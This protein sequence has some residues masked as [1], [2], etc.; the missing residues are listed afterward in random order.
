MFDSLDLPMFDSLELIGFKSFPRKTRLVFKDRVTAIIGPNGCGKSNLSDALG[1][2]LGVQTARDLRGEKM[3]DV[4]FSGTE[5]RRSSGFAEVSLTICRDPKRA[6]L[7]DGKEFNGETLEITRKLYCSG[8][9]I[10]SINQR[11]C[12]LKDIH[13]FLEDAGLQF[14][15]YA[16]IAQGQIESFLSTK[17]LDRR[18]LIEEA[19][20]IT[21]YKNRRRNAELK[22]GMTEQNLL[23][24]NDIIVEVE[25]QL[26]S[27]KR[28]ATKARRYREITEE[29]RQVQ[30]H[31]FALEAQ[32][33]Q[34]QLQILAK[35]LGILKTTQ[36]ELDQK[37]VV[38]GKTHH[39]SFVKR[40]QLEALLAELRQRHSEMVLAVDRAENSIRYQD[41]QIETTQQQLEGN[42]AE[43]RVMSQALERVVEE[44]GCL[45]VEKERLEKEEKKVRAAL[46]GQSELVEHYPSELEQV[47]GELEKLRGR[48]V[49]LSA[50]MESRRNLQDQ[51]KQHLE[52]ALYRRKRLEEERSSHLLKLEESGTRLQEKKREI[53][54]KRTHLGKLRRNLQAQEKEK[55]DLQTQL[56]E[57]NERVVESKNQL[58]AQRERLQSLQEVELNHSQYSEGVQEFLN[59]LSRNQGVHTDGTLADFIEISPEYEKLVEEFLDKELEYLLVDSLDEALRGLSE[60]KCLK[61][62]KCTFLSLNSSNGFG[63]TY[64]QKQLLSLCKQKGVKGTLSELLRMKPEVQEAFHRVL[65]QR[66]EAVVVSDLGRAF[67]L[68]HS[69]PEST[70]LTLEGEVLA[71]RGLLSA[72]VS[73]SKKL[74]LLSLKRQ[75]KTLE[76]NVARFEKSLESLRKDQQRQ[77]EELEKVSHRFA[78][79]QDALYQLEKEIIGF[80]HQQEQWEGE[81]QRQDQALKV[82]ENELSQLD[83]DCHQQKERVQQVKAELVEKNSSHREVRGMLS[84]TEGSLHRLQSE[85]G[86][87]QE[88]LHLLASDHKVLEERHRALNHT[89]KRVE[90]QRCE[91]ETRQAAKRLTHA[92]SQERLCAI[93]GKLSDLKSSLKKNRRQASQLEMSVRAQEEAYEGWKEAHLEIEG[94]LAQLR[95]RT[96]ELQ[97]QRAELDVERARFETQLQNLDRQCLEQL[98]LP[99]RQLVEAVDLPVISGEDILESHHR[100]KARLDEF[101]PINMTALKEY[102][103][104]EERYDFL[105]GQRQDIEQSIADTTRVIQEINRRSCE[106]FR[107]TFESVN[108]HFRE[109]FQKLL[110]GGECRMQLL[111]EEDLLESGIDISAQPPGKKLQNVMLLSGGEKA[112]TVLALLMGLFTYRPSQFCVLDEVD[113]SLDDANV[114]RFSALVREMSQ[115]T[116]FIIITHNKRTLEVADAFYGVSMEEAGVSQVVSARF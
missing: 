78:R 3:E 86:K 31:R 45:Q 115:K 104:N 26:R 89:L 91:L 97:E 25:R 75:K 38:H 88:Q 103:E 69:Y 39:E 16:L 85:F 17:P 19:A 4:I 44:T 87:V 6:I 7:L 81:K 47:E 113:A 22:L 57:A 5:K 109:I 63:P 51:L 80:V 55:E 54:L 11:R 94:Q 93:Q 73:S 42:A 83:Q 32:Q 76:A 70:F 27:L 1:W 35:E 46:E 62:G 92:E 77:R 12:R 9:S 21:G 105:R 112:I 10:Y 33:L 52:T 60:L 82:L 84:K 50:E 110:G 99:V 58:V 72:S 48:F 59:H 107:Q 116:Q 61:S 20:G 14:V 36:E 108:V 101:G 64:D 34:I 74:G 24:V 37:R 53:N 65:P 68:A 96:A 102:Q 8:E 66:A 71:P 100:L 30:Q 98:E 13:R 114:S 41:E 40:D 29:F 15:S 23:R 79:N 111:D 2:V 56:G 67:E 43:C 49:G 106:K 90:E 95:D 28:Q 18:A